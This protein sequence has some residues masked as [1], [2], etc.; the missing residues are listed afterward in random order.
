MVA[1]GQHDRHALVALAAV[2]DAEHRLGVDA[3]RLR[4]REPEPLHDS[5]RIDEGPVHVEKD[6]AGGESLGHP[7]RLVRGGSDACRLL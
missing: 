3:V 4:P 5:C 2:H 1:L 7:S 6:G